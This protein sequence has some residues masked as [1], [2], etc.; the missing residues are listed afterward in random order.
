[1]DKK[2]RNRSGSL[3]RRWDGK[4]YGVKDKTALGKGIIWLRYMVAGKTLKQ[5]LGTADIEE[6][7]RKKKALMAPFV[8]ADQ[9]EVLAQHT[10]KL[11]QAKQHLDHAAQIQTPPLSIINAWDAYLK[12]PERPDTGEATLKYYAGYWRAFAKW[13]ADAEPTAE[14]LKDVTSETAQNYAAK[15]SGGK[16]SPNTY[17]KHISFLTLFSRVLAEVARIEENP[18]ERIRKK[19]LKTNVRRELTIAELH[20]LLEKSS[21]ELQTLFFIGTFTGL[22]LGDCC[23]LKWGEVDL[24]RRLINRVPNKTA[25]RSSKPILVGIPAPL[26][27]KFTETPKSKRKGYVLPKYASLYT[28]R[29]QHGKTTLQAEITNE[30]QAH[31]TLCEIQTHREGTGFVKD[32]KTGKSV[33]TG[34]R[35]VVEVGFHSLRHTYVSL[36]A[37]RGTSQAVIQANVGHGS[38]AMTAHYTHIG[39]DA[40]RQAATALD[41]GIIDAEYEVIKDDPLPNRVVEKLTSMTADNWE[42]L[43][44]ELLGINV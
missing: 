28:H 25:S 11:T 44:D 8:Y 35:A 15:L 12:S 34:R 27:D 23:T 36:H 10:L 33:S 3:Y 21:G 30:I 5:S 2:G 32:P 1:M 18:F 6:A 4:E 22:R 31:F 17:N 20:D 40:A 9:N 38:P 16:L 14:F 13:L 7:K 29:N 19:K 26:H 42:Q 37:E 39:E 24:D 43:R 41:F